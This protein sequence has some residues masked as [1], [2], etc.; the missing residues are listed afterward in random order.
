MRLGLEDGAFS[1]SISPALSIPTYSLE[2]ASSIAGASPTITPNGVAAA[3]AGRS[4]RP[5]GLDQELPE[6]VMV[7]LERMERHGWSGMKWKRGF[8]LLHW[9]AMDGK[10]S[11]CEYL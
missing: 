9:A 1:R 2:T 10:R 11:L 3:S 4:H 6:K 7:A 5:E 8:T